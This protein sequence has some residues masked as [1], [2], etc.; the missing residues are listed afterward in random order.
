[1]TEGETLLNSIA[2]TSIALRAITPLKERIL[3][4]TLSHL[5]VCLA[6]ISSRKAYRN[7]LRYI[8]STGY[9]DT[10]TGEQCPPINAVLYKNSTHTFIFKDLTMNT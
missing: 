10:Y 9:I 2:D 3:N 6:N 8:E 5:Y 1:M 7:A 4:V